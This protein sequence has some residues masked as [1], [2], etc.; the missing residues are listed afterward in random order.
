MIKNIIIY[1]CIL[2]AAFVFSIFYYAWFSWYLLLCILCL[3]VLSALVSLPFM[4]ITASNGLNLS[5][6]GSD[7]NTGDCLMAI[8]SKKH[9]TIVCPLIRIKIKAYNSF[10]NKHYKG[11]LFYAGKI[12][13]QTLL[14]QKKLCQHCGN[15]TVKAKSCRAYDLM[16]IFFI[17]IKTNKHFAFNVMPQNTNSAV[18]PSFEENTIIGYKPKSGGIADFYELA[19]YQHGDS[20]RSI[21]WKLSSKLDKLIVRK[22]YEPVYSQPAVRLELTDNCAEN[23]KILASFLFA[24]LM[25]LESGRSFYVLCPKTNGISYIRSKHDV[26]SFIDALYR[27][28]IYNRAAPDETELAVYVVGFEEVGS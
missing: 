18:V 17:P 1:L 2:F 3:P 14:R 25:L 11:T 10:A 13:G 19:E 24:C 26:M 21:H 7:D 23:D 28:D 15:V 12:S 8:C 22:P 9:P 20:I 6:A 16:G 4:I 27:G 5:F